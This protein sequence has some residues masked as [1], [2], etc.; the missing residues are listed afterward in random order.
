VSQP[1]FAS[2]ILNAFKTGDVNVLAD[3][4][5]DNGVPVEGYMSTYSSLMRTNP[6]VLSSL[7]ETDHERILQVKKALEAGIP[8]EEVSRVV[9]E[10][11]FTEDTPEKK[12]R[13]KEWGSKKAGGILRKNATDN[14]VRK[15]TS[16]F[17]LVTN[18][19]E[20][21][22][23]LRDRFS[24]LSETGYEKFGDVDKA[25]DWSISQMPNSGITEFPVADSGYFSA[26]DALMLNTP[27]KVFGV[28][29]AEEAKL[30]SNFFQNEVSTM[31]GALGHTS[32]RVRIQEDNQTGETG[33]WRTF[34]ETDNGTEVELP[35]WRLPSRE[36]LEKFATIKATVDKVQSFDN[37]EFK[38][39]QLAKG[40]ERVGESFTEVGKTTTDVTKYIAGGLGEIFKEFSTVEKDPTTKGKSKSTEPSV[41][42][43]LI[44]PSAVMWTIPFMGVMNKLIDILSPDEAEGATFD[45]A[46]NTFRKMAIESP[47]QADEM[48]DDWMMEGDEEVSVDDI[49]VSDGVVNVTGKTV[50]DIA[51]ESFPSHLVTDD[52]RKFLPGR[53]ESRQTPNI[54][55]RI[56]EAMSVAHDLDLSP[57]EVIKHSSVMNYLKSLP[58]EEKTAQ[59]KEYELDA[60]LVEEKTG[61]STTPMSTSSPA[62]KMSGGRRTA[63]NPRH[64]NLVNHLIKSEQYRSVVYRD[65]RR[66]RTVNGKTVPFKGFLTIGIGWNIHPGTNDP[67]N[68]EMINWLNSINAGGKGKQYSLKSLQDGTDVIEWPDALRVMNRQIEMSEKS[69]VSIFGKDRFN[70]MSEEVKSVITDLHF[71][72]GVAGFKKFTNTIKNLKKSASSNISVDEKNKM[73]AEGAYEIVNSTA[74]KSQT[75]VRFARHWARIIN[76][77]TMSTE[78]KKEQVKRVKDFANKHMT[79]RSTNPNIDIPK[80]VNAVF[81]SV[82]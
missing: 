80:Q 76:S 42:R 20:M 7:S 18:E 53:P 61:V 23:T 2:E 22:E 32:E 79:K 31:A 13:R 57:K 1:V 33:S 6:K 17:N 77:S 12:A 50:E 72:N 4:V 62:S 35:R 75:P 44:A 55:P 15:Y 73:L 3:S 74:F 9:Q 45:S 69:A 39:E 41:V 11:M 5:D 64:Q 43:D 8:K 78:D 29:N 71:Q 46:V 51:I 37:P 40:R 38:K 28:K 25:V 81:D 30:L 60:A 24:I 70:S 66:S 49:M 58:N 34:V 63:A 21:S 10:E 82:L 47:T 65:S 48:I 67:G 19:E 59:E 54:D 36:E 26:R 68:E 16:M 52:L 14:L 56:L 27:E